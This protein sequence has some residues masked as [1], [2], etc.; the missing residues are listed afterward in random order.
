MCV[1]VVVCGG[2]DDGDTMGMHIM[3]SMVLCTHVVMR[4]M[5]CIPM[6]TCIMMMT[7]D[8][9][10]GTCYD[11][12]GDAGECDNVGDGDADGR[13]EDGEDDKDG[14]GD[15]IDVDA[16]GGDEGDDVCGVDADGYGDGMITDCGTPMVMAGVVR[17]AM[18]VVMMT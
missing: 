17:I 8:S 16:D 7:C 12:S 18:D 6:L 3:M 11:E 9:V 2:G 5:I 13:N 1:F 10:Y 4:V 15:D 14:E